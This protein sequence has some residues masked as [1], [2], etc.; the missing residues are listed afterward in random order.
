MFVCVK[1]LE[2]TVKKLIENGKSN[3]P[4]IIKLEGI[5]RAG[6][7]FI[8]AYIHSRFPERDILVVLE[9]AREQE[10]IF[11][12]FT[13]WQKALSFNSN[14]HR[15]SLEDNPE[16][17]FFSA[18]DVLPDDG[19]LPGVDS[20]SDRLSTISKLL[21]NKTVRV[22]G[23]SSGATSLN[24]EITSPEHKTGVRQG[25][26]V[27]A[28]AISLIQK[29]L[30]P[31]F[32]KK[33]SLFLKVGDRIDPHQISEY[34]ESSFYEPVAKV[35]Q[36]GEF[37]IRGGILDVYPL[38]SDLPIR[39]EFFGD[40][41]DSMRFFDPITQ[42]SQSSIQNAVLPPAGEFAI[43][44]NFYN[45]TH[46]RKP[47]ESAVTSEKQYKGGDG[48]ANFQNNQKLEDPEIDDDAG[49]VASS[50]LNYFNR[51]AIVVL[52]EPEKIKESLETFCSDYGEDSPLYCSWD[53]LIT[54]ASSTGISIIELHEEIKGESTK[55]DSNEFPSLNSENTPYRGENVFLANNLRGILDSLEAWRPLVDHVDDY[56]L[57]QLQTQ[58]FFNQIREWITSGF[59]AIIICPQQSQFDRFKELWEEF[60]LDKKELP[61]GIHSTIPAEIFQTDGSNSTHEL[62]QKNGQILFYSGSIYRGFIIPEAKVVVISDSEVFG[63]IK[64]PQPRSLKLKYRSQ[65][66]HHLI[67]ISDLEEGDYVVHVNYG[68]G[69]FLGLTKLSESQKSN[70]KGEEYLVI[71]YAPSKEGQEPPKLYVPVSES[72]LI[73]KYI[74]SG[75]G[76]PILNKLTGKKW[77]KTKEK[78]ENAIKDYAAELLS[79]QAE[80]ISSPG[81]AFPPDTPWQHDFENAFEF[82]ETPD[83]LQAIL[84]TKMDMES[85]K[86]MDRLV[87]GDAGYGKTE[88]ALRA[89]FKAVMSGKQVAVLVP[90]TVLAQQHYMTFTARMAAFPI[91]ICMLSRFKTKAKQKELIEKIAEG[92]IDIVIGTHRLIQDDVK[93]HDL[94][95]LIIDE[96]QRFGVLHKEKLKFLKRKVDVL[97]LS[98]TPIPRTLYL[99]LMGARD[100]SIIQ[101]PPHDRLPIET[102][103]ARYDDNL[104]R[105]AI[106]RELNRGGQVYYL[107]N[108]IYDIEEVGEK[109]K[110]LVPEAR[111]VIGHGRMPAGKLEKVMSDFVSGKADVLLSTTI[112]E[113][114]LDIPNANTII[115]DRADKYG[116]SDLYQL[117]GRVGRYRRQAYAYLLIPRHVELL[118][119]ARKRISAIKQYSTPG[120]GF[121]V[122]MRDLEIRGAGNILGVEQSGHIAAIGFHLYCQLLNQAIKSLKG[123]KPGVIKNVTARFD[124]LITNPAQEIPRPTIS[125]KQ[126]RKERP[127]FFVPREV[128]YY[129]E[130]DDESWRDEE[131]Q[132]PIEYAPAYIPADY[133]QD[134]SQRT[135]IYRKI[136]QASTLEELAQVENEI[137]D[138]FGKMPDAVKYFLK[139]E[140][141]KIIAAEKGVTSI[142]TE[143]NKLKILRNND[144]LMIGGKFPRLTKIK[145]EAKLREIIFLL[146]SLKY[147]ILV[148][149]YLK[150]FV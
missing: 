88:V 109:L 128:A 16:P 2:D 94:G 38:T 43:I 54:Q 21:E 48:I 67:D 116:L 58:T 104:V 19:R 123:Q 124:F 106:R 120:S 53:D 41:I 142:E 20:L 74:G 95:L 17:L 118:A 72:H 114:G 57:N 75:R 56:Q 73:T 71:E 102:I 98:A 18:W 42:I 9:N 78:A 28:S 7:C 146:K 107:H 149:R 4:S 32:L 80:R 59:S 100:M 139:I 33:R 35:G 70:G 138:R 65:F 36:K 125:Q 64:C 119:D 103:V 47:V 113:N 10:T 115:I 49:N 137:K 60:G 111:I 22:H 144:Y 8:A 136:A 14:T 129:C 40:L 27:I 122:A 91:N 26:V 150:I 6:F 82:E 89:A 51:E 93:F 3:A 86:P 112:V 29:T 92:T 61:R 39:I 135:E 15:T 31:E 23:E 84:E 5:D 90:T 105:D 68:I 45:T 117:R 50:L 62:R 76:R 121:K 77:Q 37:S 34:L 126:R 85:P 96:E 13:T 46:A 131:E 63:R 1:F 11:N 30:S 140:E 81:F 24:G 133:I 143:G 25:R 130:D 97:T 132:S 55:Y 134:Y 110:E 141:V 127:T 145:P 147:S 12:D 87:C 101:T 44:K 52:C 66:F 83:Q 69:K 79:L 148:N 99:A 108:Q